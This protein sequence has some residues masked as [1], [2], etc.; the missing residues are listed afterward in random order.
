MPTKRS[1]EIGRRS[2]GL[3]PMHA[4]AGTR[5]AGAPKLTQED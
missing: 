2:A 1:R 3:T 5:N 4:L